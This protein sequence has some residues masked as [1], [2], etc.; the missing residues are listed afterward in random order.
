MFVPLL[1]WAFC[2]VIHTAPWK[3]CLYFN[4]LWESEC[5]CF[6]CVSNHKI[7]NVAHLKTSWIKHVGITCTPAQMYQTVWMF[8]NASKRHLNP[9]V[10]YSTVGSGIIQSYISVHSNLMLNSILITWIQ[11]QW[12]DLARDLSFMETLFNKISIISRVR[13]WH[14]CYCLYRCN[15]KNFLISLA[16]L[17]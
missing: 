9:H 4:F 17:M 12:I 16:A 8:V 1:W 10:R 5:V 7:F 15:N 11:S 2:F 14:D 13:Y 6:F 3:S